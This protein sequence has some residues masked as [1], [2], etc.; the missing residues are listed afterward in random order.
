MRFK[1]YHDAG[2]VTIAWAGDLVLGER[3]MV[4]DALI[5]CG[6]DGKMLVFHAGKPHFAPVLLDDVLAQANPAWAKANQVP[7]LFNLSIQ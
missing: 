3:G 1:G 6:A 4:Q 5:S 7:W 2:D